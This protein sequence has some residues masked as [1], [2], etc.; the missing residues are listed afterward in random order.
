[1]SALEGLQRVFVG[2]G[3]DSSMP[4]EP[5]SET[6]AI[7]PPPRDK[8]RASKLLQIK[9]MSLWH[10]H[11]TAR[12]AACALRCG[13]RH[14]KPSCSLARDVVDVHLEEEGRCGGQDAALEANGEL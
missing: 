2:G 7:T 14:P 4:A 3:K 12:V 11:R 9:M 13:G 5:L 10:R 8:H 6:R 1:M